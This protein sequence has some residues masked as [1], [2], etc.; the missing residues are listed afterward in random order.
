MHVM[1]AALVWTFQDPPVI[2]F[3]RESDI[4]DSFVKQHQQQLYRN[5]SNRPGNYKVVFTQYSFTD[6]AAIA[7]IVALD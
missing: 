2:V 4:N 5:L 3:Q 7:L 6:M 1:K